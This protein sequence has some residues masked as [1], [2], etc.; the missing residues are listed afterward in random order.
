MKYNDDLFLI[1]MKT[2]TSD[3]SKPMGI[4]CG[5]LALV[6]IVTI[7]P[8]VFAITY[9]DADNPTGP[10]QSIGWMVGMGVAAVMGGVGVFTAVQ[11]H[12]K[13]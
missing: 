9:T 12:K 10:M 13:H 8:H 7:A 4:L 2:L 6:V 1:I 3:K 11:Y 5:I